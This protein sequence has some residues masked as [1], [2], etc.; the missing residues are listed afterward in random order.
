M[1]NYFIDSHLQSVLNFP[2]VDIQKQGNS[3]VLKLAISQLL[4]DYQYPFSFPKIFLIYKNSYDLQ[5]RLKLMEAII[6]I[7]LKKV[8]YVEV[9][10]DQFSISTSKRALIKKS[11][12]IQEVDILTPILVGQTNVIYENLL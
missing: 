2:Y 9:F 5:I 3:W 6:I 4:Y 7:P 11:Q 8:F 12:R 1:I 10:I